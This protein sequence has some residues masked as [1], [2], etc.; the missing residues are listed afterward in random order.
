VHRPASADRQRFAM[1]VKNLEFT[2]GDLVGLQ[3]DAGVEAG[4]ARPQLGNG[5]RSAADLDRTVGVRVVAG[6]VTCTF[7]CM[8]PVTFV[9]YGVN[10]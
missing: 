3:I 10:P 5:K 4:V 1:A 6:P 9:T 7:A 2:D 8:V